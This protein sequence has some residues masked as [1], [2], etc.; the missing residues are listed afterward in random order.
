MENQIPLNNL[1]IVGGVF[2]VLLLGMLLLEVVQPATRVAG[3]AAVPAVEQ[4]QP[5]NPAPQNPAVDIELKEREIKSEIDRLRFELDGYRRE[6]DVAEQ[7][8]RENDERF[9]RA[10]L[11]QQGRLLGEGVRLGNQSLKAGNKVRDTEFKIRTK[12]DELQD[13]YKAAKR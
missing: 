12:Q 10:S 13:L 9:K 11:E 3:M 7:R 1:A 8:E 5:P 4:P 2:G 6:L